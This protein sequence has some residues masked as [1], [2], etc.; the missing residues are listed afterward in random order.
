MSGQGISERQRHFC[1]VVV[2][3]CIKGDLWKDKE[4]GSWEQLQ[5]IG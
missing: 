5:M 3:G 4:D 2:R 1:Q